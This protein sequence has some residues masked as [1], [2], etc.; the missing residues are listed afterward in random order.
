MAEVQAFRGFRY[1]LA[2]VGELTNSPGAG[3]GRFSPA[4]FDVEMGEFWSRA[5]RRAGTAHRGAR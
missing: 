4:S 2:R 1:D 3:F 5:R